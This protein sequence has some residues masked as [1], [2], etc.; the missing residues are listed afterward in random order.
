VLEPVEKLRMAD[1]MEGLLAVFLTISFVF[2]VL[3]LA[4]LID[5]K[6]RGC[7]AN[8]T[9]LQAL[10]L[11]KLKVIRSLKIRWAHRQ[12]IRDCQDF[13]K[14]QSEMLLSTIRAHQSSAYGRDHHFFNIRSVS[15]FRRSQPVTE[16]A[17]FKD[18]IDRVAVGETSAMFGDGT[19]IEM[20]AETSGTTGPNKRYP[21]TT[22][23]AAMQVEE[24]LYGNNHMAVWRD[25]APWNM[26]KS[27][28][29]AFA[30]NRKLTE[31]GYI[32][33]AVSALLKKTFSPTDCVVTPLA[34]FAITKEPQAH[35]VHALFALR[36]REL[37]SIRVLF[38]FTVIILAKRMEASQADL[39][40]DIRRGRV[41]DDLDIPDN[42]RSALN[43]Q[44]TPMPERAEEIRVAFAVGS[45]GLLS[46][47]WPQMSFNK[48]NYRGMTNGAYNTEG[49]RYTGGKIPILDYVFAC[50]EMGLVAVVTSLRPT[51]S[52]SYTLLPHMG[53]FEFL[54]VLEDKIQDLDDI[55]RADLLLSDELEIGGEYELVVTTRS[56]LYRYRLGDVF[57]VVGFSGRAPQVEF[58]YRAGQI[59]NIND[60][61]V[62]EKSFCAALGDAVGLWDGVTLKEYTVAGSDLVPSGEAQATS[63]PHYLL[64]LELQGPRLTP[65]QTQLMDQ[66]LQHRHEHYKKR[67]Q[68]GKLGAIAVYQLRVGTFGRFVQHVGETSSA[69]MAQF[70]LPRVLK[71]SEKVRWFL[72]AAGEGNEAC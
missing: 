5:V 64:F 42:I 33:G 37:N 22:E 47:L 3:L 58:L 52:S 50:S 24:T 34:G 20:L 66:C 67:R 53:F 69:N 54:P 46:R 7:S 41:K 35:Y 11:Y 32:Q 51:D 17:H 21:M 60:E 31:A 18:Y 43:A 6:R 16:F 63:D 38:L 10:G 61:M 14:C 19:K 65:E 71:T 26:R 36:E 55:K 12:F 27:L 62:T 44:L 28:L 40:A 23:V 15:D 59:L 4:I 25:V 9:W 13:D 72:E 49:L 1:I 70:K 39:V 48:G 56:G 8:L 45:E 57:R 30:Q 2:V 68:E 29:V